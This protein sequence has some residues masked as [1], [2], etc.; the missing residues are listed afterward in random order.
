MR[1]LVVRKRQIKTHFTPTQIARIK[2]L[3]N[4]QATSVGKDVEKLEPSNIAI[5]IV[6]WCNR[7]GKQSG[8]FPNI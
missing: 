5:R 2:K 1:R 6:K 8:S 7:F 4:P 3:K